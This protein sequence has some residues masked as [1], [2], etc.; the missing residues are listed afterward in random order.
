MTS[1]ALSDIGTEVVKPAVKP[2]GD[3]CRAGENGLRGQE[4]GFGATKK[5]ARNRAPNHRGPC[6]SLTAD[7]RFHAQAV[8]FGDVDQACNLADQS[9]LILIQITVHEGH[10]PH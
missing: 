5:L 6:Q 1:V 7:A 2:V 4:A 10:P 8:G 9:F 3:A